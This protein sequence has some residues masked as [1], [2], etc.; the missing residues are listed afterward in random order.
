MSENQPIDIS[1]LAKKAGI[2]VESLDQECSERDLQDDIARLCDDWE[3][4]A[5][6]IGLSKSQVN[7]IKREESSSPEVKRIN[8]L[9]KWKESKPKCT[10]RMLVNAFLKHERVLQA[11]EICKLIKS[12]SDG[13]SLTRREAQPSAINLMKEYGAPSHASHSNT[14]SES[15]NSQYAI[16]KNI[17]DKIRTLERKFSGVQRQFM[18]APGVALEEL[19]SCLATLPSFQSEAPAPLLEAKSKN[20]FFHRLKNYCNAQDPDILEDLVDELGDDETKTKLDQ[21]SNELTAFQRGTKLK[22]LIGNY[23]G[24]ENIPPNYKELSI[25]LGDNWHEKTLEDLKNVR[26]KISLRS[27]LLKLIEDGS[28]I[29][30]YMVPNNEDLKL[31]DDQRAYLCS[32][33]VKEITMGGKYV[34]TIEDN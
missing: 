3:L 8:V 26:L 33:N 10:Y 18:K 16:N 7:A 30:T 32:Q 28:L 6:A 17:K 11:M 14:V 27:W 25:K 12:R 31:T 5:F 2:R 23:D 19:Q 22:D 9:L 21:F 34:F 13:D 29:V 20:D 24:P 1:E 4:I 15:E